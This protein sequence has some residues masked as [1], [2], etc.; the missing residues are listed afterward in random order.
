MSQLRT[1]NVKL[2]SVM[3]AA[4]FVKGFKE[5]QARKPINYDSFIETRDTNKQWQYE[6]GRQFG[7]IF[8]GA[9]KDGARITWAAKAA[10]REAVWTRAVI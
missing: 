4:A 2:E 3:R 9:L 6:R 10:Y 1:V 7:L 5:G 8:D